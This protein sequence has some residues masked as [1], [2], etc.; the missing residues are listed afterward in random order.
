MALVSCEECKRE[1]SDRATTCPHCGF[2]I[3][4]TSSAAPA[5]PNPQQTTIVSKPETSTTG[6]VFMGLFH[7]FITLP[8]LILLVGILALTCYVTTSR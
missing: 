4:A 5:S 8:V 3:G 1:V 2:P 6:S 7:F